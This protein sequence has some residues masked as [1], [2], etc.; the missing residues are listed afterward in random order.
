[1]G[2]PDLIE[3]VGDQVVRRPFA[4]ACIRVIVPLLESPEGLGEPFGNLAQFRGLFCCQVFGGIAGRLG[5]FKQHDG[6]P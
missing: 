4:S 1:M 3:Y 2:G 6:R 5:E